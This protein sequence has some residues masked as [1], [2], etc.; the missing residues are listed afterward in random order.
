[1]FH[2]GH[3]PTT[4]L[5][6]YEDNLHISALSD[7]KLVETLADR[8]IN[9]GYTYVAHLFKQYRNSQLGKRNGMSMF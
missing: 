3:S 1:M 5:Y 9:P 8:A 4:A 7:E 2:D 6:T